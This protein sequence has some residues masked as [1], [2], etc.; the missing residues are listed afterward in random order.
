M[1]WFE[2]QVKE[3]IEKDDEDEKNKMLPGTNPNQ[4]IL[5]Y[6]N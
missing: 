5:F 6:C 4:P 3:R 2:E 1:G